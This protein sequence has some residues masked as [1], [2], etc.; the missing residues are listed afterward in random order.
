VTTREHAERA[1]R[2]REL[3]LAQAQRIAAVGS[4]T[5]DFVSRRAAWTDEMYRIYDR[6]PA[7]GPP[8]GADFYA[9]LHADDRVP[10]RARLR[11]AL[12]RRDPAARDGVPRRVHRPRRAPPS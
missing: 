9:C 8:V 5:W 7:A 12:A 11:A 1:L 3:Q 10:L 2:E 6:D 4:W